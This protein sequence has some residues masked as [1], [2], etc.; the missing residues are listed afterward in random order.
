MEGGPFGTGV[1]KSTTK[2]KV[3]EFGDYMT[4]IEAWAQME[5]TGFDFKYEEAT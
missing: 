3:G 2:L 4:E 1:P 5:W